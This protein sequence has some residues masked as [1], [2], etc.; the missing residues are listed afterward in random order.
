MVGRFFGHYSVRDLLCYCFP[1]PEVENR[2]IE[3]LPAKH[4]HLFGMGREALYTALLH[5]KRKSQARHI[6]IPGWGCPIVLATIRTAGFIPLLLDIS[7]HSLH[8]DVQEIITVAQQY[9]V[10][11]VVLI[12]ENGIPY[13]SEEI[14]LIQNAG[15]AVIADHAVAWQNVN[16]TQPCL[17]DY[18]I[19]SGGFSKP[20]CGLGLRVLTS[21]KPI[22]IPERLGIHASPTDIIKMLAHLLLQNRS[23]Y[24]FLQYLLPVELEKEFS[25]EMHEHS[26]RSTA[27]VSNSFDRYNRTA[28]KRKE[29]QDS[30]RKILLQKASEAP[31][32]HHPKPLHTKVIF[33]SALLK[34]SLT[35]S[36]E[37]HKQYKYDLLQDPRAKK[38]NSNY[39][40]ITSIREKYVS[41]TLNHVAVKLQDR[42]L[43]AFE[44]ALV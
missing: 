38:I 34:R 14:E 8:F 24:F 35:R 21:T 6:I 26:L 23:L 42:F 37:F 20:I 17:S 18:E 7:S 13:S 30:I 1:S 39:E 40:N 12:S 19:F 29:M 9:D 10:D 43:R 25:G 15:I 27:V 5:R 31:L 11:S 44:Q 36:I 3:R 32:V 41:L 4:C 28:E 16:P 22:E 2:I 33:E